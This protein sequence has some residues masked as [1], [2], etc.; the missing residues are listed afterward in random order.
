MSVNIKKT[1]IMPICHFNKRSIFIDNM[2]INTVYITRLLGVILTSDLKW[3]SHTD[4]LSKRCNPRLYAL[5]LLKKAGCPP[6]ILWKVY[7]TFIRSILTYCYPVLCNMSQQLKK[8]YLKIQKRAGLIIGERC[9]IDFDSF[10]TKVCL[11][12]KH[13][14]L[15]NQDHPYR[16]LLISTSSRELRSQTSVVPTC[17]RSTRC[18]SSYFKMFFINGDN[19]L[20]LHPVL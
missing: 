3:N 11:N 8:K 16:E 7:Y 12:L 1:V 18:A 20:L 14:I 2:P 17:P 19:L 9:P 13:C 10:V 6:Q 4:D 15:E 5:L